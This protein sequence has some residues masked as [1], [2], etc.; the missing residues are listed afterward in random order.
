LNGG[1]GEITPSER[2]QRRKSSTDSS[3]PTAEVGIFKFYDSKPCIAVVEPFRN[4]D[5]GGKGLRR[6]CN[7]QDYKSAQVHGDRPHSRYWSAS[8]LA[9]MAG[10]IRHWR[11]SESTSTFLTLSLAGLLASRYAAKL[12]NEWGRVGVTCLNFLIGRR[13]PLELAN[14]NVSSKTMKNVY[15]CVYP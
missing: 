14:H 5:D 7:P 6:G 4:S 8:N 11:K 2:L 9:L 10:N 15:P 13:D 3:W 1:F 12:R